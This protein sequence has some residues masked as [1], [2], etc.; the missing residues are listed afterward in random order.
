MRL[1]LVAA[2]FLVLGGV[3]TVSNGRQTEAL[4]RAS[5]PD[6]SPEKRAIDYLA[7]EVQRWS[8]ENNCFS[9]HN[10]GDGARALYSA[11]ALGYSVDR[12][13]LSDTSR[14][15]AR[16]RGWDDNGG[17]EEYGSKEL[18]DLQF[19]GALVSSISAAG[20]GSLDRGDELIAAAERV[21][22]HQQPDGTWRIDAEGTIG[23]PVTYGAALATAMARRVLRT[24]DPNRFASQIALAE[25]WLLNTQ[26]KN[27]LDA[28][29][30]LIGLEG[31][32]DPGAPSQRGRCLD[33]IQRAQSSDGGWGPYANV[34][35]E[36]FDTA[37]VLLA[38]TSFTDRPGVHEM[39]ERGRTFLISIQLPAGG[40]IE[41]TRPP[42]N[43][44]YAQHI[45]TTAWAALA[46]LATRGAAQ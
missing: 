35:P 1:T 11:A 25:R 26:P 40:W 12:G 31:A 2:T 38:I 17:A 8:P 24:A 22:S 29:G 15:I 5:D 10:N 34:P 4:E 42:G 7:G 21:A 41:T 39:I 16:P 33:L 3:A 36:A 19:A 20:A 14:W 27:V 46:L 43:D 18:S 13:A 6:S 28:G 9:C 44:S 30:L 37:V 32:Q 45:S 23:S